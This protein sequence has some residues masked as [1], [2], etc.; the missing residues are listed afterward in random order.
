M[1]V[2]T[3]SL[4]GLF[5]LALYIPGPEPVKCD[6]IHIGTK[7]VSRGT[8]TYTVWATREG[9]IGHTTADGT[10]ILRHSIFVALPSRKALGKTVRVTYGTRTISCEVKDVGPWSTQDPYWL[11]GDRPLSESGRRKPWN[12]RARNKAGIDLSD[13]LW[14]ALGIKRGVGIVWVTWE[15]TQ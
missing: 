15:F 12:T 2:K 8:K 9:L 7:E 3:L 6:P 10:I 5:A 1:N 4:V 13:G 14:D 11:T